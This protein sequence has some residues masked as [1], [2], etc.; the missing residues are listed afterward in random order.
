VEEMHR[1]HKEVTFGWFA[2]V[3]DAL[4]RSRSRAPRTPSGVVTPWSAN[5][6]RG[7]SA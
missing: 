1:T 3:L 6:P 4:D 2:I 5:A 7:W